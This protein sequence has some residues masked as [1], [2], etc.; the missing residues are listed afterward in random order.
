MKFSILLCTYNSDLQSV[1]YTLDSVISQSLDEF[2]IIVCDDGSRDSHGSFYEEYFREQG[3]KNYS[4]SF[5][6]Q[7]RGTV[8]NMLS[9]AALAKG[10]YIKPIGPGDALADPDVL[11]DMYS[12]MEQTGA[13]LGYGPMK[14]FYMQ[15]GAQVFK[16]NVQVPVSGDLYSKG[17]TDDAKRRM[18]AYGDN[19]SGS[20]LFYEKDCFVRLLADASETVVYMED[21]AQYQALLEGQGFA[22][23]PRPVVLYETSAGISTSGSS[24]FAKLL[25]KDRAQFLD[26]LLKKYPEEK[27]IKTRKK[28]EQIDLSTS[29]RIVKLLK[30]AIADPKWLRFRSDASKYNYL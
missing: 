28:M 10:R 12:L 5:L 13:S 22:Y 17:A 30:K 27:C 18:I 19:I 23:L 29:K 16:E 26:A 21:I 8:R 7:N 2:E 1:K 3:F 25:Q 9:G 4:F 14:A 15:D 24:R 20:Q 6:E 11:K